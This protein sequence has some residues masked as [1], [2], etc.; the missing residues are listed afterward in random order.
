MDASDGRR[1]AVYRIEAQPGEPRL[2]EAHMPRTTEHLVIGAGRALAGRAGEPV[3][4]GPGDYLTHPGD[5]PHVFQA[6]EPGTS[7]V[8]VM[9]HR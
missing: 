1:T 5:A 8:I 6:L 7:A 3:E 2:S 9:E 4:L